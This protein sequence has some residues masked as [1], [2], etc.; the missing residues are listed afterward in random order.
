MIHPSRSQGSSINQ[1]Y[2]QELEESN[3]PLFDV[4]NALSAQKDSVIYDL[5]QNFDFTA[6]ILNPST[7][8]ELGLKQENLDL[9]SEGLKVN[10]KKE[11]D[12]SKLKPK[13]SNHNTIS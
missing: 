13:L 12:I 7:L 10:F 1:L 5:K 6:G 11:L 2:S 9:V 4:F 3:S 8:K